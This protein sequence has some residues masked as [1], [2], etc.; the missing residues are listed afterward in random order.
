MNTLVRHTFQLAAD[1][2]REIRTLLDTAFDGDFADED[3]EHSLGG[4]HV[5]VREAGGLVAHGSV[6]QRRVVHQGQ[7]LRVGYVEAVAVREDRRRRGLG[8]LVMAELEQII[9]RAYV[10]GALS[11]SDDGARLYAVRGWRL[12][13]GP[14][15][16]LGPGG[17]APIPEEDEGFTYVW[18]PP[19]GALP[20]PAAGRLDFDWRDGDVL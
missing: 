19:G 18:G 2:P 9:A 11:A 5:L 8:G 12:W 3:F 10:F 13:D 6:V 1:E 7:A 20:D 17:R 14:I 4:M 15:H 16:V